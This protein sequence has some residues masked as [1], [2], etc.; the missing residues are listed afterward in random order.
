MLRFILIILVML[1]SSSEAHA[2]GGSGR[3]VG[4][5]VGQGRGSVPTPPSKP[6]A[7]KQSVKTNKNATDYIEQILRE[8]SDS[9]RADFLWSQRDKSLITKNE[10][11][12]DQKTN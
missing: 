1:F 11:I 3:G 12:K 10:Q 8:E 5:G 7:S 6:P 4:R 2:R 9:N